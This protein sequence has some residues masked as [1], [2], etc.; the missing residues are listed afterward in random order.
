MFLGELPFS[1]LPGRFSAFRYSC[2]LSATSEVILHQMHVFLP[3]TDIGNQLHN[4]PEQSFQIFYTGI[5][6]ISR[7]AGI[8]I[9]RLSKELKIFFFDCF[10]FCR[11]SNIYRQFTVLHRL[12][13]FCTPLADISVYS[14][15]SHCSCNLFVLFSGAFS[16]I[17]HYDRKHH[18]AGNTMWGIINCSKCMCHRMC[19]SKSYI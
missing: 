13:L 19:D 14:F 2:S 11:N 4:F 16:I 1:Y 8:C 17:L 18:C 3:Y 5:F 12:L 9:C 15:Y 10:Q 6:R 7:C